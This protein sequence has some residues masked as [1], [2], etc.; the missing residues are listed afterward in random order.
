MSS[1]VW[2]FKIKIVYYRRTKEE[3]YNNEVRTTMNIPKDIVYICANTICTECKY[4]NPEVRYDCDI[5]DTFKL[6]FKP[7]YYCTYDELKKEI[8]IRKLKEL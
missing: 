3:D 6:E 2:L 4:F 7:Y 1:S 8:I 5:I